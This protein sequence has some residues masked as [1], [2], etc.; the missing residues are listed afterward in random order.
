MKRVNKGPIPETLQNYLLS[1]PDKT[2]EEMIN[3]AMGGGSVAAHAC[4]DQAIRDQKGLCAYCEQAISV[5]D[6]LHRRIEHYHPKSDRT[7]NH[8]WSL[9]WDNMLATCDGGSASLGK[10]RSLHPLPGNLSCDAHKDRMMQSGKLPVSCEGY[11]LNPLTIPTQPNLFALDKGT[12][13]LKPNESGGALVD[14][15]DNAFE[16]TAALISET[17][18]MLNLNCD[19][20]AEKRRRIVIDIDRNKKYLR[21]RGFTPAESQGKLLD[22]YFSVEWPAFFTTLRCCFGNIAED[23][24]Q[25]RNYSG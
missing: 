5:Q 7:G 24:L 11:L 6:P 20:L 16:T 21:Q 10:E 22:R 3:D 15:V 13:Y 23:Y 12:G 17:I 1:N 8:N 25:S 9:D 14:I 18:T 4:R 2:W 19:R